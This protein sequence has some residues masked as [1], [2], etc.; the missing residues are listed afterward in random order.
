MFLAHTMKCTACGGELGAAI[1]PTAHRDTLRTLEYA[2]P[3][4]IE[5]IAKSEAITLN[6]ETS[7]GKVIA[8]IKGR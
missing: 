3:E 1:F 8:K 2:C 4:C 5:K 7:W 6:S